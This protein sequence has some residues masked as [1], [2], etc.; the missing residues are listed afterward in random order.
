MMLSHAGVLLATLLSLSATTRAKGQPKNAILLSSV[1]TLTLRAGAQT[2]HRRVSSVPQLQ[3]VSSKQICALYTPQVMRCTNQGSSYSTEDIEWSCEASL[4]PE[5]K[6]GSTDVICEGYANADDPF[7]LK[8]SCGVEYRLQL[9]EEGEKR[10]PNLAKGDS[11]FSGWGSQKKPQDDPQNLYPEG[12]G[13]TGDVIAKWLFIALFVGVLG[14][15]LISACTALDT[16]VDQRRRQPRWGGGGGGGFDP[17]F[18]PD[19]G[20]YDDNSDPPPPYS[21]TSRSQEGW[22]PGFWSGT[23][24]GAAAGY[25]AS[26]YG[27]SRGNNE[28]RGSDAG[29]SSR[30]GSGFGSSGSGLGSSSTRSSTGFGSTRRR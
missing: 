21:K 15:I 29:P 26:R 14:W 8:G 22:R 3:C 5:L 18:G 6:L 10:Y 1:K 12:E 30:S 17:G 28:G 20:G 16:P 25:A 11:W 27:S 4:P 2:S 9:T 23:A 7:V 13:T 24:A 19:D